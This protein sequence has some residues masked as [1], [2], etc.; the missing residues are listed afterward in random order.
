MNRFFVSEYISKISKEDIINYCKKNDILISDDDLNVIY[1]Y[2]KNKYNKFFDDADYIIN[3]LKYKL[4]DQSYQTLLK[5]YYKYK[6]FI[7]KL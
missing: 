3:E 7:D 2:L 5:F 1:Y 6:P 4:S